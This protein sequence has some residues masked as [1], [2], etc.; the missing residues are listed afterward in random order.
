MRNTVGLFL[1][2]NSGWSFLTMN[3]LKKIK[4]ADVEKLF[5]TN[6]LLDVK[7]IDEIDF[8]FDQPQKTTSPMKNPYSIEEM[9][10]KLKKDNMTF[11]LEEESECKD[12]LRKVNYYTFKYYA[13][14]L[15][16]KNTEKTFTAVKATYVF[17][18]YLRSWLH[19]LISRLEVFLRSSIID[20]L[21]QNY[22]L[23]SFQ[24]AQFYL[25][26]EI[27]FEEKGKRSR[28]KQDRVIRVNKL[29]ESFHKTIQANKK[30][31]EA[32][33]HHEDNYGATPV[34]LLFD[35]MTLGSLSTFYSLLIPKYKTLVAR[36]MTMDVKENRLLG[37][38]LA[39]WIDSLR[40]LR[41]VVSHTGKI[42]GTNFNLLPKEHEN[43]KLYIEELRRFHYDKR[44]I[45][46]LLFMRRLFLVMSVEDRAIWDEKIEELYSKSKESDSVLLSKIGFIDGTKE[47]LLINEPPKKLK[48]TKKIRK[49]AEKLLDFFVFKL[50]KK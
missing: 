10:E 31:H 26:Q 47:K 6:E 4:L 45:I 5:Y 35:L 13:N 33:K 7:D 22:Q 32:I 40:H 28:T 3:T 23:D 44:L 37:D 2:Q 48:D 14:D 34:W 39:S 12:F 18:H 49:L 38:L 24:P 9:I 15:F 27:Y 46:H 30:T 19:D 25:D 21:A 20:I 17:D 43:D 1:C 16:G 36:K 41:N 11:T 29:Y 50:S 42:Y 8:Y